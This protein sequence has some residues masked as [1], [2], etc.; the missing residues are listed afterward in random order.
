MVESDAI[1]HPCYYMWDLNKHICDLLWENQPN[2][3]L[4]QNEIEARK[5]DTAITVVGNQNIVL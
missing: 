4:I 5:V 3:Q 2:C 1:L